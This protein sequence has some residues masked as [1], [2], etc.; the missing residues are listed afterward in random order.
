MTPELLA[1]IECMEAS[2]LPAHMSSGQRQPRFPGD[3]SY[4]IL[5]Q[6]ADFA[7]PTPWNQAKVNPTLFSIWQYWM[8]QAGGLQELIY[9]GATHW[10]SRGRV[11][12]I[13]T[14]PPSLRAGHWNHVHVAVAKGWRFTSEVVVPETPALSADQP[15]A[16]NGQLL[17]ISAVANSEGTMTG[18]V[19]LASDGGVFAFGPGARFFG[20]LA[21]QDPN[22]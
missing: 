5:G 9:A 17:S 4:H 15:L 16:V 18:Y 3:K 14:L 7:G 6:A 11:L 13:S 19:I 2:G 21:D 22:R 20:R 8:G 12:P 1:M 10:I